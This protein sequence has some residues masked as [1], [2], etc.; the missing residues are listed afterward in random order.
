MRFSGDEAHHRRV[1]KPSL[2]QIR[3]IPVTPAPDRSVT[4]RHPTRKPTSRNDGLEPPRLRLRKPSSPPPAVY[5]SGAVHR[6]DVVVPDG[7]IRERAERAVVDASGRIHGAVGSIPAEEL[8]AAGSQPAEEIPAAGDGIE[9]DVGSDGDGGRRP[10][11][12]DALDALGG[13]SGDDAADGAGA[14]AVDDGHRGGGAQPMDRHL[15]KQD[16]KNEDNLHLRLH[17]SAKV[18]DQDQDQDDKDDEEEEEEAE[19]MVSAENSYFIVR[20]G[21]WSNGIWWW[22]YYLY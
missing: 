16:E 10:P 3:Y 5:I 9:G 11:T 22:G 19:K 14:G 13:L 4:L 1:P 8:K 21:E 15:C 18:E 12:G 6:A 17:L 7:E 20:R 2:Y